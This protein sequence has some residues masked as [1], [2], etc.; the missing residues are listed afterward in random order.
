MS[1]S[2]TSAQSILLTAPSTAGKYYYGACVDAVPGESDTTDNCSTAVQVDVAEPQRGGSVEVTAPREWMPV[3]ATAK[4]TARVLDDNGEEMVGAPVSWSSSK[5]G[6]ATVDGNGVVTAVAEGS[7]T[8][9]ATANASAVAAPPAFGSTVTRAA[10]IGTA[11]NTVTGSAEMEVVQRAARV[12]LTPDSVSFDRVGQIAHLTATVF[13]ADN[14]EMR[15]AHWGFGGA[16]RNVAHVTD[17]PG[18]GLGVTVQAIGAGTTTVTFSANGSATGR[19]TVTVTLTGRRVEVWPGSLL[20]EALGDIQTV[21][22]RV[23][24]ENG[25]NEP[26][27]AFSWSSLFSPAF[28][29]NSIGDG[30]MV[31][32]RLDSGLEITANQVGKGSVTIT[33]EDA[34][35]AI[36]LVTAFQRQTVLEVSPVSASLVPGQT[37]TLRATVRDPNGHPIPISQGDHGGLVVNWETS[38]P[39]VATVEGSEDRFVYPGETGP[40]AT[41]TGAGAGTATITARS[42]G[43][44]RGTATVTVTE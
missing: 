23:L 29:G 25:N 21:T 39:D 16:N 24:D 12:E 14:N 37:V 28:S 40:T 20:F 26:G 33:S 32:E 27:T 42:G 22:V 17:G 11:A 41:V 35:P 19:A 8:V 2:G 10:K 4:F 34:E 3:G 9:T 5:P 31:V 6:V 44:V 13:D 36:L 30:G 18:S 7:V 38:D 43:T 1:A 15:P